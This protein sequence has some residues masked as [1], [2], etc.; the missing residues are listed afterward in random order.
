[1]TMSLTQ[2]TRKSRICTY[3]ADK[4][5]SL[6][7]MLSYLTSLQIVAKQRKK[8]NNKKLHF[9]KIK[10]KIMVVKSNHSSMNRGE[11]LTTFSARISSH[12]I[13][14]KSGREMRKS[15][16][17]LRMEVDRGPSPSIGSTRIN[18]SLR[19]LVRTKTESISAHH[20]VSF[21]S[22]E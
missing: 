6:R 7:H 20:L 2:I 4:S 17:L 10:V 19:R 16:R 3:F 9:H 11:I 12:S 22:S 14:S 18:C 15:D 21:A 5:K 8:R 1:M 13:R